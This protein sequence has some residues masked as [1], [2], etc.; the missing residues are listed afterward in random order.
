M[1]YETTLDP[2]ALS[3]ILRFQTLPKIPFVIIQAFKPVFPIWL[4]QVMR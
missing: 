3:T 2:L 4:K 1:G